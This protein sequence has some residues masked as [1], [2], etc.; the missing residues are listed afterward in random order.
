MLQ[1]M[2]PLAGQVTNKPV[3]MVVSLGQ[4]QTVEADMALVEAKS[5]GQWVVVLN[6][7]MDYKWCSD[8]TQQLQSTE[9]NGLA[10]GF[11]LWLCTQAPKLAAAPSTLLNSVA[12]VALQPPTS[13]M[14]FMVRAHVSIFATSGAGGMTARGVEAERWRTHVF[15]LAVAMSALSKFYC[16]SHMLTWTD[17]DFQKVRCSPTTHHPA[18][19]PFD[20]LVPISI[21][22]DVK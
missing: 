6:A 8:T 2:S 12:L 13:V 20:A 4:G 19:Q 22:C 21:F 17:A 11:R 18:S 3:V 5:A 10:P 1:S 9:H 15:G 14:D 16:P 7:H